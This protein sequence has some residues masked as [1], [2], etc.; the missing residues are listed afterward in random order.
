MN[1]LQPCVNQIELRYD[2]KLLFHKITAWLDQTLVQLSSDYIF[3]FAVLSSCQ[4]HTTLVKT[5]Y[6]LKWATTVTFTS[7]YALLLRLWQN[8]YFY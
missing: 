6:T 5:V 1:A 3:A 8:Y 4:L 2:S 7:Y